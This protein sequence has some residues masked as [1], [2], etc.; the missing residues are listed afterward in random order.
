MSDELEKEIH[1]ASGVHA[2][3]YDEVDILEKVTF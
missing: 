1:I 2:L 3:I